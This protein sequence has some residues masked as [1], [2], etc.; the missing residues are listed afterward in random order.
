[1]PF[2]ITRGPYKPIKMPFGITI[3]VT[4]CNFVNHNIGH[5]IKKNERKNVYF[6]A[7]C[8][9]KPKSSTSSIT[10]I[11]KMK[12]QLRSSD[13]Q[14][15]EVDEKVAFESVT[16]KNMIE[17]MGDTEA[18]GPIPLRNVSS[19]ILV[20][21]IEYC[22]FHTDTSDPARSEETVKA[23][24]TEFMKE[25][26]PTI[27]E[28]ILASNYLDIKSLLDLSSQTIADVVKGKSPDEIRETFA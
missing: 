26:Y 10:I 24:D 19:D 25:E 15:F 22:K 2:G 16:I 17:D 6:T 8:S 23:W 9:K 14:T 13:G 21:I 11:K 18:R 28:I 7:S 1:M 3:E 4:E 5:A 27:F 20:K 12:F